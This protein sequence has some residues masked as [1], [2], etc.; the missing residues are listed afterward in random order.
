MI[1]HKEGLIRLVAVHKFLIQIQIGDILSGGAVILH[2]AVVL[3]DFIPRTILPRIHRGRYHKELRGLRA[4]CSMNLLD[5]LLHPVSAFLAGNLSAIADLFRTDAEDNCLRSVLDDQ[6]FG[7]R[8]PVREGG[9]RNRVIDDGSR[10]ERFVYIGPVIQDPSAG[11][12]HFSA[13]GLIFR[14]AQLAKR[15][16]VH[17]F[18]LHVAGKSDA[19]PGNADRGGSRVLR[20]HVSVLVHGCDRRTGRRPG[21]A[22]GGIPIVELQIK[23]LA[24]LQ[25]HQFCLVQPQGGNVKVPSIVVLCIR[26]G[27]IDKEHRLDH[28]AS[29]SLCLYVASVGNGAD[30]RI[31]RGPVNC[32][33]DRLVDLKLPGLELD[34]IMILL[35]YRLRFLLWRRGRVC[36]L[37]PINNLV[38]HCMMRRECSCKDGHHHH[39][40]HDHQDTP[41]FEFSYFHRFILLF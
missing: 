24:P 16:F 32:P 8:I 13:V 23:A 1:F 36:Y 22:A 39:E 30:I 20:M 9:I 11:K 40:C 14:I 12:N 26:G 27:G 7:P 2:Q 35:L 18:Y 6:I 5:Q 4:L 15:V 33:C 34:E 31:R 29:D 3:L 37:L 25:K 19:V 21:V 17:L 10:S 38:S 41:S 28:T